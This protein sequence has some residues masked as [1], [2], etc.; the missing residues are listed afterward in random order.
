MT[1]NQIYIIAS[2]AF[3][4]I[5]Y[6]VFFHKKKT[7]SAWKPEFRDTKKDMKAMTGMFSEGNSLAGMISNPKYGAMTHESN[8]IGEQVGELKPVKLYP[9][10][11]IL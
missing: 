7:E 2:I 9:R 4:V 6:F 3:V 8:F 10:K 1:R 5:I 11:R